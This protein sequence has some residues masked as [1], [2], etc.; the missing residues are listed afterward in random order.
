MTDVYP[1]YWLKD[2]WMYGPDPRIS[3]KYWISEDG[4]IWGPGECRN[5]TGCRRSALDQGSIYLGAGRRRGRVYRLLAC[6][7]RIH[8]R[9]LE[10]A[11]VR[12]IVPSLRGC[13][14]DRWRLLFGLLIWAPVC[15]FLARRPRDLVAA[16][17]AQAGAAEQ[18]RAALAFHR[19]W[20]NA[21]PI[22]L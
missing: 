11:T 3:G 18:D 7:R 6:R 10:G 1:D 16:Q 22:A 15:R 12:E 17:R 13:E 20:F 19:P 2:D 5:R 14:N 21:T 9:P 4:W 8:L